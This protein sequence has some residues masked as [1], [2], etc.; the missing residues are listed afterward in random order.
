MRKEW[1]CILMGED[2]YI[3]QHYEYMCSTTQW[4]EKIFVERTGNLDTLGMLSLEKLL[5]ISNNNR[6]WYTNVNAIM[7]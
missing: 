1:K 6:F 2:F 7:F 5:L 4:V 3:V